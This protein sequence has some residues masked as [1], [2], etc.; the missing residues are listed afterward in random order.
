M[1]QALS[2][3]KREEANTCNGGD[4]HHEPKTPKKKNK[5]SDF[6]KERHV[7]NGEEW[8][9]SKPILIS[10]T[11]SRTSPVPSPTL[12]S[13]SSRRTASF[14][15]LD[16]YSS[17]PTTPTGG[18]TPTTPTTP[19]EPASLSKVGSRRSTTPIFFS[20]SAARRKPQ[21]IEKKLECTLEELCLGC[22]KKIKIT[23]DAISSSGYEFFA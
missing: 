17:F 15:P 16:F 18:N 5:S 19:I 4:H 12:S 6:D 14:S 21:P 20:Q 7:D 2:I 8:H 1:L 9:I 10:R 13:S 11:T 23:R 3:K 22:V